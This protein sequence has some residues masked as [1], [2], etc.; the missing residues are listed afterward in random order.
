MVNKVSPRM[1]PTNNISMFSYKCTLAMQRLL[2]AAFTAGVR[3]K[4]VIMA[5]MAGFLALS[6]PSVKAEIFEVNITSGRFERHYTLVLPENGGE[7][8][9][10][11]TMIVLHGSMMS[12]KSMRRIFDIEEIAEREGWAVVY[13]DA[14][15]RVWNDGRTQDIDAPNDVHFIVQLARHLVGRGIADPDRLYLV[16]LSSGGMLTFRVACEAPRVFAAYAALVANMPKDAMKR[17]R[18]GMGVPML[19]I[20]ARHAKEP[21]TSGLSDWGVVQYASPA[22]TTDFWRRNNG[23]DGPPQVKPMPDKDPSDGST[24]TAEQHLTCTSGATVV[25]FMVENGSLLPPGVR[26]AS[27]S[28]LLLFAGGRPNGD[29]SAAEISWKFFRRF[30]AR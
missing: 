15:G 8:R 7:G 25:S 23:C 13:P 30:P 2:R 6:A 20:N 21:D 26:I 24:V 18:P 5:L 22:A 29:I 1:H 17:C 4:S 14:Y 28:P 19:L 27:R 10:L 11:P 3:H 9:R 12:S 16:G